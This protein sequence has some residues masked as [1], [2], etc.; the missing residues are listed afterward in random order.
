MSTMDA[1]LD[2][3]LK[4]VVDVNFKTDATNQNMEHLGA[5]IKELKNKN[6]VWKR[7]KIK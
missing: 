5:I 2:L 6:A 3:T 4:C 1:K 7:L